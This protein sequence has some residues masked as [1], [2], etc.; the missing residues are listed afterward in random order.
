MR[1]GSRRGGREGTGE[2]GREQERGEGGN[3]RGGEGA[4]EGGGREQERGE[5]GSRRGGGGTGEGGG[6]NRRGGGGRGGE[7]QTCISTATD[8]IIHIHVPGWNGSRDCA[9][10][11][12]IAAILR[13]NY[14]PFLRAK[15]PFTAKTR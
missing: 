3:R 13:A 2:G 15:S 5:G 14:A 4:G 11:R 7:G 8:A 6:G 1:G 9:R 12:G 10:S